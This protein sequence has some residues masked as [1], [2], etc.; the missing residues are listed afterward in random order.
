MKIADIAPEQR[1]RERLFAGRG[2]EMS[3][4][5][6]LALIWGSGQKGR[7]IIEMAQEILTLTGGLSGLMSLGLSELSALPGLGPAKAGQLWAVQEVAR[8]SRRGGS[9]ARMASPREAG[10]YLMTRC[11]GWTEEHFGLL[12]L[13]SKSEL[14]ADR[15]L[16][17]GTAI[18]TLVTPREF[19]REAMRYG[20][21]SAIAF[22]NHPSGSCEPSKEDARLTEKLQ[23]AG[24]SIGIG[25]VDHIIVGSGGYHSMRSSGAWG[26]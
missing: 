25:L 2:D 22:H 24:D 19:F 7:N 26:R 12:A 17:K 4:A 20:A 21:V 18:G 23:A 6:L 14:I 15:I 5:D 3:D 11:E 13:N 8:R 10:E 9:K 16:S 1:P